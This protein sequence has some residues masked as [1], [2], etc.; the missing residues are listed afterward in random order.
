MYN[1]ITAGMVFINMTLKDAELRDGLKKSQQ[2]IES[3]ASHAKR[4]LAEI[5]LAASGSGAAFLAVS[6]QV[7]SAMRVFTRF[8]DKIRTLKAIS[9]GTASAIAGLEKYI[10]QQGATTAFTADQIADGT[11][12]L[13]RMGFEVDELQE[14][15]RPVMDLV[16]A[17]GEETFKLGEVSDYAASVLRIF[18]LRADKFGDVCDVMAF[19]ANKSSAGIADMGEAFKIAGPSAAAV[20]EDVR[21]T[22][23][24][25]MLMANAGIK[26]SL[27]G[28]SLRK[29]YQ[30]IAAESGKTEGLSAEEIQAGYRGSEALQSLGIRVVD[31]KGNLRKAADVMVDLARAVRDMK[32][33]EK[34]NFATEVFDLRGSLGALTML[35]D[36]SGQMKKFHSEMQNIAGYAHNLAEEMESGPGGVLRRLFAGLSEAARSFGMIAFQA[37]SPL[38]VQLTNLATALVKLMDGGNFAVSTLTKMSVYL[39]GAGAGIKALAIA[40]SG[41]KAMF[42]PLFKITG[43]FDH[44]ISGV[45]A[46]EKAAAEEAFKIKQNAALK[47]KAEEVSAAQRKLADIKSRREEIRNSLAAAQAVVAD[48]KKKLEAARRRYAEMEAMNTKAKSRHI[49]TGQT[50][51][52][53]DLPEF[54]TS[55]K[56]VS[57]QEK[58][59]VSA[60]KAVKKYSEELDALNFRVAKAAQ[61]SSKL[62]SAYNTSSQAVFAAGKARIFHVQAL[63]KSLSALGANTAGVKGQSLALARAMNMSARYA[64]VISSSTVKQL[65]AAG[66]SKILALSLKGVATAQ[67]AVNAAMKMMA[68][69]PLGT[70]AVVT[71]IINVLGQ[72][73]QEYFYNRVFE[74]K[75]KA[76]VVETDAVTRAG[77]MLEGKHN[78]QDLRLSRLQQL[79]QKQEPL[80]NEEMQEAEEHLKILKSEGVELAAVFDKAGKRFSLLNGAD[81]KLKEKQVG[82]LGKNYHEL[83]ALRD[84]TMKE[85]NQIPEGFWRATFSSGSPRIAREQREKLSEQLR[86]LEREIEKT[87]QRANARRGKPV[88]G[89]AE[90]IEKEAARVKASAEEIKKA[91]DEIV[92]IEDANVAFVSSD[93]ENEIHKIREVRKEYEK[94]IEVLLLAEKAKRNPNT[95]YIA[96]L[97]SRLAKAREDFA[98]QEREAKNKAAIAERATTHYFVDKY[99]E[100][101]KKQAETVVSDK[102]S[103]LLSGKKYGE[104]QKY[105][106]GLMSEALA[107]WREAVNNFNKSYGQARSAGSE[108]GTA[109][110]AMEQKTLDDL[111]KAGDEAFAQF[112]SYRDRLREA[113]EAGD[114]ALKSVD[115][116]GMGDWSVRNL[117][118]MLGASSWQE[119]TAKATEDT[120][121]NTKRMLRL[122]DGTIISYS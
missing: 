7:Y 28:T 29:I 115:R 2:K 42:A 102:F 98:E 118:S 81:S 111:K 69:N 41:F 12:E 68:K 31:D 59:V 49:A 56:D 87:K 23:A 121:K 14:A 22:A 16:R 19:A 61:E 109:V 116:T 92:K 9:G 76:I 64:L 122:K 100:D 5:N 96:D 113:R 40:L 84:K 77:E 82:D 1:S 46:A 101:K 32:T 119:R 11:V 74:A 91:T 114:D 35:A 107:R 39:L 57:S 44:F 13:S 60:E 47:A 75:F 21:D 45:H 112:A 104:A 120:A 25:L 37:F 73:I 58:S 93:L 15:L 108:R 65:Q 99:N 105:M 26:G 85:L 36:S 8:D 3:F 97:E 79:S 117:S 95:S 33:G 4:A 50:G 90:R 83:L 30:S 89:I 78:Q 106:A 6:G 20:N 38:L 70:A 52:F 80:S 53:R 10:R 24:A 86:L 34:I 51:K 103:D 27:A 55:S 94:Y 66:A 18:N 63:N 62:V 67:L 54:K 48:E 43:F 17:T 110:S 88:T 71:G 72:G